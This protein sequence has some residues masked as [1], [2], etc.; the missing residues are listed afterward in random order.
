MI[1][2]NSVLLFN[3]Y[4]YL[5]G[6]YLLVNVVNVIFEGLDFKK[7]WGSMFIDFFIGVYF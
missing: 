7:F 5:R 3:L 1:I 6:K 2:I 4:C